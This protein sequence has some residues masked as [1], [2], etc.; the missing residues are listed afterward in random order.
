MA[1]AL[2]GEIFDEVRELYFADYLGRADGSKSENSFRR[3]GLPS[4]LAWA[5]T[6]LL[7][8]PE[9][10]GFHSALQRELGGQKGEALRN[11]LDT[12]IDQYAR[13]LAAAVSSLVNTLD[14]EGIVF[15][16]SL[17]E[18]IGRQERFREHFGHYLRSFVIAP[19]VPRLEYDRISELGWR[20]AALI[21]RDPGYPIESSVWGEHDDG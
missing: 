8:E 10:Q 21:G 11:Y 14:L 2:G 7:G 1:N 16:G 15:C 4:A 12:V 19:E 5:V 18:S 3:D 6:P 13:V 9:P 20:G 17:I